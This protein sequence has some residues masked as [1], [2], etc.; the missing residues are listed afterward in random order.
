VPDSIR[1][2][3]KTIQTDPAFLEVTQNSSVSS[4]IS[5][6]VYHCEKHQKIELLKKLIIEEAYG[7]V[8]IFTNTKEATEEVAHALTKNHIEARAIHS[9]KKQA[10]REKFIRQ[11]ADGKIN[12]L[13]ATDLVS[14]GIDIETV[15][16]VINFDMPLAPETYVHRIGRTGRS[17]RKGVAYSFCSKSE[18]KYFAEIEKLSGVIL[19]RKQ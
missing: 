7:S 14:R 8:L 9:D 17:E 5:Q 16:M 12:I 19:P 6:F 2:F 1:E 4:Q 13:V 15:S 18:M 3:S 10:D 11:F